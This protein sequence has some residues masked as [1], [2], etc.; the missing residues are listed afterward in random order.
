[1]SPT[2]LRRVN[3]QNYTVPFVAWNKTVRAFDGFD[4]QYTPEEYSHQVDAYLMFTVGKQRF[5]LVS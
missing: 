1:M 5:N 3:S 2:N 4:H